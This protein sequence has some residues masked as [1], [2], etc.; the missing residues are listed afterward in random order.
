MALIG[1][2]HRGRQRLGRLSRTLKNNSTLALPIGCT[3][4]IDGTPLSASNVTLGTTFNV[5]SG[6]TTTCTFKATLTATNNT[7]TNHTIVVTA[8]PPSGY[9]E[10]DPAQSLTTTVIATVPTVTKLQADVVVASIQRQ[11]SGGTLLSL[12]GA[13]DTVSAGMLDTYVATRS[14]TTPQRG[15]FRSSVMFRST[16]RRR[17]LSARLSPYRPRGRRRARSPRVSGRP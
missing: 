14:K 8:V 3:V 15:P 5:N 2:D 17:S 6:S 10:S 13:A 16:V 7:N 4:T 12:A 9:T 11:L 1:G